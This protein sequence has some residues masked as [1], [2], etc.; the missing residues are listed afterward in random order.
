MSD[1]LLQLSVVSNDPGN[2]GPII[3]YFKTKTIPATGTPSKHL[4]GM[5]MSAYDYYTDWYNAE[6]IFTV[7]QKG[8]K[9]HKETLVYVGMFELNYLRKVASI[10]TEG[11]NR[12][13]LA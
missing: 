9:V 13:K 10:L 6:F 3:R 4:E 5:I 12:R 7:F 2:I 8:R 11:L 1:F